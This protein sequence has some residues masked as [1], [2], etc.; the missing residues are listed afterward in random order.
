[1][2]LDDI[3]TQRSPVDS[4]AFFSPSPSSVDNASHISIRG[5]SS[6]GETSQHQRL[7]LSPHPSLLALFSHVGRNMTI[8]L[9]ALQPDLKTAARF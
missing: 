5:S 1:V 7:L 9:R 2:K 3:L 6:P 4:V 8:Y